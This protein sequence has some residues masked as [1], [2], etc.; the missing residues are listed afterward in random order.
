MRLRNLLV[1]GLLLLTRPASVQCLVVAIHPCPRSAGRTDAGAATLQLMASADRTIALPTAPFLE[2]GGTLPELPLLTDEEEQIVR[3]G[4][5]LRWQQAPGAGG[6]GCGFAVQE[7]LADIDDVWTALSAFDQYAALIS[8][9]RTATQ[10][11]P[12]ED[13]GEEPENVC[14]Y[15]FLVSRLRLQLDV[16]FSVVEPRRF[17]LWRLDKPSWVLADSTGYWHVEPCA[18]RPE[19][20]RVWFCVSVRLNPRVP[21]LVVRLV[22]RLGLDKATRWLG[23]LEP[24]SEGKPPKRQ[25]VAGRSRDA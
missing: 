15:R 20:V 5:R 19:A 11:E 24:G 9:V 13:V 3:S 22:S 18:G 14:R 23:A 8:T 10:Y 25:R 4:E 7:L 2:V 21:K 16:R 6:E 12:P 17:A 1:A